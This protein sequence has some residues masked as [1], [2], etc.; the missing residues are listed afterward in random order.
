MV[1]KEEEEGD[2]VMVAAIAVLGITVV[3]MDVD[4][5][6]LPPNGRRRL[7][8]RGRSKI[9][10]LERFWPPAAAA[11]NGAVMVVQQAIWSG[12]VL[13]WNKVRVRN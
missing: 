2:V 13:R 9:P 5:V 4:M 12:L 8:V 10:P 3:T 7:L 11:F 6:V 1:R